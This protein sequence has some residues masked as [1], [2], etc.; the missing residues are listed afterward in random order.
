MRSGCYRHVC[1][2]ETLQIILSGTDSL[3]EAVIDCP[4]EGGNVTTEDFL[5]SIVC[6][7]FIELCVTPL[8]AQEFQQQMQNPAALR[9]KGVIPQRGSA[10]TRMRLTARGLDSSTSAYFGSVPVDT[11][12]CECVMDGDALANAATCAA[13]GTSCQFQVSTSAAHGSMLHGYH[14]PLQ[15]AFFANAHCCGFHRLG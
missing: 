8:A 5:G 2:T 4:P 9:F 12:D 14:Y 10:G 6:P 1:Q 7:P 13:A 3:L 15:K 11:C